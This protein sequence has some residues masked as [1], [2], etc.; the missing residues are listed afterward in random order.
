LGPLAE[1]DH[2]QL[3]TTVVWHV[4]RKQPLRVVGLVNRQE[5]AKQ[6]DIVLA[7]TDLAL[8]GHQLVTL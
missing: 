5:P 7:S 3:S 8:E 1:A 4:T 6:R 2:G